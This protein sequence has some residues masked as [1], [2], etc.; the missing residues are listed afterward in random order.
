MY[1]G[2]QA[3]LFLCASFA[4]CKVCVCGGGG[5]EG[6]RIGCIIGLTAPTAQGAGELTAVRSQICPLISP[7]VSPVLPIP[8]ASFCG[9]PNRKRRCS[10]RSC[11]QWRLLFLSWKWE[12]KKNYWW[13]ERFQGFWFLFPPHLLWFVIYCSF[14]K[15]VC[16]TWYWKQGQDMFRCI[17]ICTCMKNY[18]LFVPVSWLLNT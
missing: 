8:P 6:G 11:S 15:W 5:R 16:C 7:S 12:W 14:L 2:D 17:F 1:V 3:G 13:N 18:Y 10:Y 9:D 4:G